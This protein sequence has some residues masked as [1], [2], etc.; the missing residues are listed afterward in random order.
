MSSGNEARMTRRLVAQVGNPM[1][2]GFERLHP[3][4]MIEKSPAFQCWDHGRVA[5]SPVGTVEAA[6]VLPSLRDLSHKTLQPSVETLGY[7]RL[8]LRD[9]A[10]RQV[11]QILAASGWKPALSGLR[12]SSTNRLPT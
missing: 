6:I 2:P 3:E 9:R 12:G 8:S 10:P 1:A 5:V 11:S 4:R 7:F